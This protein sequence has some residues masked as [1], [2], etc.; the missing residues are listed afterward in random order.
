VPLPQHIA[1]FQLKTEDLS[2][3]F[4]SGLLLS[5]PDKNNNHNTTNNK[6]NDWEYENPRAQL[7]LT[8]GVGIWWRAGGRR[9]SEIKPLLFGSGFWN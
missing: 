3:A 2:L 7:L 9:L 4:W 5:L 1:S 8:F 6:R